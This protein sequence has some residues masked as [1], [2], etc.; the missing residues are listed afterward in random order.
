MVRTSN[1]RLCLSISKKWKKSIAVVAPAFSSDC[2]ETLEEIKE[3]I[4]ES[5][6]EAGGEQFTYIDCLN[7]GTITLRFFVQLIINETKGWLARVK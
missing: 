6:L 5:F 3:E 7:S 4:R 1:C 2:I